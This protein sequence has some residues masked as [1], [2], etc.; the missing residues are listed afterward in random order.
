MAMENSSIVRR[1]AGMAATL[2][3]FAAAFGG[4]ARADDWPTWR[5]PAGNGVAGGSGYVT[6]WGPEA[7]VL[8]RAKLPGLG[9]STP[10]VWGDAVV[11]T[12]SLDGKNGVVCFDRAGAE[13]WRRVLGP[14]RAGKHKKATGANS[15]PVTDGTHVWAYFKSGELA[16]LALGSGDVVWSTN[17]QERF[18]EDTLWWDLGTSPVLT[19]NAVVVAV[20]QTG[21]SYVV[22]FDQGDRCARLEAEPRRAG[23][24]GGGPELLD[25]AGGRGRCS[26][27]GAGRDA[28]RPGGR[29]RDGP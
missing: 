8:W 13:R 7:N 24:R 5:G 10:A 15:S 3:S 21:P 29:S 6:T 27:G 2:V 16:C 22:A 14:E 23:A 18:G 25:A 12:C 17:L 1:R 19:K 20:M 9:A 11:V 4:V 26:E 28:R